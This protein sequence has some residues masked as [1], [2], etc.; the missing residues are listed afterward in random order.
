MKL[1][2]D[3]LYEIFPCFYLKGMYAAEIAK[4]LGITR[5]FVHHILEGRQKIQLKTRWEIELL[6]HDQ[7]QIQQSEELRRKRVAIKRASTVTEYKKGRTWCEDG[8]FTI[9]MLIDPQMLDIRYVGMTGSTLQSRLLWHMAD[10]KRKEKNEWIES[11]KRRGLDPDIK[12]IESGITTRT[13]AGEREKFWINKIRL[14]GSALLLNIHNGGG[15]GRQPTEVL[16]RISDTRKRQ[17]S[18]PE[19]KA[20]ALAK[21][22][23]Q[24]AKEKIQ[25]IHSDP[26]SAYRTTRVEKIKEWSN[27]DEGRK[28]KRDIQKARMADPTTRTKGRAIKAADGRTWTS[29]HACAEDLGVSPTAVCKAIRKEKT[30]KGITLSYSN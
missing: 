4:Q 19:Y 3:T 13:L 5:Q 10:N 29:I 27:S 30:C 23:S 6:T 15:G 7:H 14:E 26:T 22:H 1:S 18:D 12:A 24:E 9:Y 11:L 16:K 20:S 25:A 17:F 21:L 8:N 28:I 2:D